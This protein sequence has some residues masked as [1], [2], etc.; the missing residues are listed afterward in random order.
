MLS[1]DDHNDLVARLYASAAG[2]ASWSATLAR[3]ATLFRSS[4]MVFEIH[5]AAGNALA[6]ENHGYTREF[7]DAFYASEVFAQDPRIAYFLRVPPGSVYYD[8]MLYDMA[9]MERNPCV[10]AS[11]DAL[12]VKYQLGTMLQLPDNAGAGFA[13]LSTPKEGHASETAIRS[14]ERLVPHIRQAATLGYVLEREAATRAALLDA[15]AQKADGIILLDRRGVPSFMNDAAALILAAD[16]GLRY[17]AGTFVAR[18]SAETRKLQAMVGAAVST[19]PGAGDCP[20]GQ[21]FV[22]RPSG[23]RP[24]VL[25]VLPAPSA[26]RFLTQNVI[27]CVVHIQDLSK[28]SVPS[29]ET[30]CT[31]F[32]LTA[33]E[34]EFAVEF[35]HCA[36]IAGAAAAAGMSVNTARNHLQNIF[37]KTNC[38]SQAE[39][40]QLLG[41]LS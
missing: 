21:M 1:A 19:A 15:L 29:Q 39:L 41:K 12:K 18:R 5:D 3:F 40:I 35:V 4:A 28:A 34:A 23:K 25:R 13:I 32:G 17:A 36:G 6:A 31:V 24:Y 2:D 8:H 11:I 20:G 10:R 38:A 33:R 26:E 30:L 22:T 7:S 14:F 16:D 27:A 37:R 9:K